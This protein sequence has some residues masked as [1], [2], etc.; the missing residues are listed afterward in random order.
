MPRK[1]LGATELLTSTF[2]AMKS[3]TSALEP[4]T[5]ARRDTSVWAASRG[6]AP[7]LSSP[8]IRIG[9][10]IAGR[11]ACFRRG[12]TRGGDVAAEPREHSPVV[13]GVV[14]LR[15]LQNPGQVGEAPVG[16]DP[17]ERPGTETSLGDQLVTI[18]ARGER[19]LRVVQVQAVQVLEPDDAVPVFPHGVEPV[20]QVV[21][22]GV[23]V[24]GVGAEA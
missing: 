23:E 22:G 12:S 19:R 20:H 14:A 13:G 10:R 6:T 17:A 11:W 15:R 4:V 7:A 1:T 21:A 18:A 9:I 16:H 24:A 3:F 2:C 8:A 5:P